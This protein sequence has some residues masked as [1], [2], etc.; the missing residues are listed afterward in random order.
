MKKMTKLG[1]RIFVS[2]LSHYRYE[3]EIRRLIY[4]KPEKAVTQVN[5]EIKKLVKTGIIK[6][7]SNKIKMEQ[8]QNTIT[9]KKQDNKIGERANR[10]QYYIANTNYLFK[11]ISTELKNK[12]ITLLTT[13]EEQALKGFLSS[14][15]FSVAFWG[16]YE[17]IL[18]K[19]RYDR[20]IDI[21]FD[22]LSLECY[23]QVILRQLIK[24]L[25]N[26]AK[27]GLKEKEEYNQWSEKFLFSRI[28]PTKFLSE[29]LQEKL[30]H[31]SVNSE[32]MNS[33]TTDVTWTMIWQVLLLNEFRIEKNRPALTYSFVIPEDRDGAIRKKAV[34][35]ARKA[36][37]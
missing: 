27:C 25:F 1:E 35:R 14:I 15:D 16:Y 28:Y 21:V 24:D 33:Y 32:I 10:R 30:S 26:R 17:F 37:L 4:E 6:R 8:I 2:T 19:T 29:S 22:F 7:A 9:N 23:K 20:G 31:L 5:R 3:T 11:I 18:E 13:E 34:A 36:A 12:E